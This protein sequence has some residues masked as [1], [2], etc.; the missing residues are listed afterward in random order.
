MLSE[1]TI[2]SVAKCP[3]CGYDLR[4]VIP[5]WTQQCPLTG[6]CTECGLR[7]RWPEVLQPEKFEPRWC[8]EYAPGR[9]GAIKGAVRT[10]LRSLWPWR[11]WS[12][13]KMS[14]AVRRGR[15]ALYLFSLLLLPV[16]LYAAEQATIAVRVRYY[17]AGQTPFVTTINHSYFAAILEAVFKPTSSRSGGSIITTAGWA[18]Y[19]SPNQLHEAFETIAAGPGPWPSGNAFVQSIRPVLF[20]WS[21][22]AILYILLP[23]SF[24]LLPV[25]RRRAKVRWVHVARVAAY[26]F[27]LPILFAST[28]FACGMVGYV[29]DN[30]RD[31]APVAALGI[32]LFLPIPLLIVWW[33]VAI[34]R[35]LRMPHGWAVAVLL[36]L[37]SSLF[38]AAGLVLAVGSAKVWAALVPG[39]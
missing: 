22:A 2:S 28:F 16:L 1:A 19:A 21:V 6:T 8:V 31:S 39:S 5:T 36:A 26:S 30:W 35:Y 33:A 14:H 15:L 18:P 34:K 38:V 10:L 29:L 24:I 12:S 17:L 27:F 32:N 9:L 3:R 25:S 20:I 13:L 7:F 4:G 37:M 23:A 11:F